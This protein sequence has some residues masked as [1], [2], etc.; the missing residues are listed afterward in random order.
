MLR[1]HR[2]R[3]LLLAF[4]AFALLLLTSINVAVDSHLRHG[5]SAHGAASSSM[6]FAGDDLA[7]ALGA[8]SHLSSTTDD[9]ASSGNPLQDDCDMDEEFL[10]P[11][12]VHVMPDPRRSGV[13]LDSTSLLRS[14]PPAE[15]LRPP[16]AA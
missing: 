11:E 3:L 8:Q 16:R 2:Y 4:C 12:L 7:V 5:L 6:R 9:L 14:A 10:T 1:V 15:L 13:P